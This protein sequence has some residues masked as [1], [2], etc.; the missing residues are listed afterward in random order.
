MNKLHFKAGTAL[1]AC[2]KSGTYHKNEGIV[3]VSEAIPFIFKEVSF[4]T[5]QAKLKV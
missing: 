3:F 1:C 2:F 4:A 5:T